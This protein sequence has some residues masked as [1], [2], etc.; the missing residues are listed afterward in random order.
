MQVNTE[1]AASNDV[2]VHYLQK[3]DADTLQENTLK[4]LS[5]KIYDGAQVVNLNDPNLG[6]AASGFALTQRMQPME[7]LASTKGEKM[8]KTIKRLLTIIL[9]NGE[10]D[11][12]T[13]AELV[14]G[15]KVEFTP[16]IPHSDV[17]ESNIVKN[18]NGIISKR[19]LLSYLSKVG[20]I[21]DEIKEEQKDKAENME[22]FNT[23]G[24]QPPQANGD[25]P[26][27]LKSK[28]TEDPDEDQPPKLNVS[29]GKGGD[30]K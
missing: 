22:N 3:P 7:M 16:N 26:P 27:E 23:A 18:L 2:D 29:R 4:H 14:R 24:G 17:D 25:Y 10:I 15:F 13:T 5:E 12:K 6:A 11:A 8:R 28:P 9:T 1:T 30:D 19:L 21:D 20:N